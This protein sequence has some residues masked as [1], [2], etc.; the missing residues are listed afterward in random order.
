MQKLLA[1]LMLFGVAVVA[2]CGPSESGVVVDV[3][4][5]EQYNVPEGAMEAAM[6]E[7]QAD[8]AKKK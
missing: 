1:V 7:M 3:D 5:M 4:E 8:A 6:E 2:G